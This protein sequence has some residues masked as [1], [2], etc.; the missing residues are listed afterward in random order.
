[1]KDG[2]RYEF[3]HTGI[4]TTEIKP[5]EKYSAAAKMY[6]SDH[7]GQ[8]R[9]QWHRFE[10]DSPLHPLMKSLPHLAFKVNDLEAAIE[11]EEVILGPYE[12]IDD[13]RVA[14]INDNGVPVEL[15]QTSLSDEVLWSRAKKGQGSL[16]RSTSL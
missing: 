9:I 3:H 6:T 7:D 1:M 14:V 15:I 12:P 11:G 10:P 13:Y 4:P 8:F 16:Y 5:N 2:I